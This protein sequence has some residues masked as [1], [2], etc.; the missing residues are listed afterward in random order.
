TIQDVP[1]QLHG[2]GLPAMVEVRGEIYFPT[3]AFADLNA[4][5]VEAGG[6][7]LANPRNAAPGSVGAKEPAVPA[8][9]PLRPVVPGIG[10]REGFAPGKQS[11]A[12]GLLRQWGLPTSD[13][14][15]VVDSLDGVREFVAY[16]A[17]H[18]HDV[19][20]DIDGV[21]VKVD[22][23]AIQGRLGSTSRAPRW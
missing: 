4:S 19:E 16:Y 21:V 1:T 20:H 23:V 12:Y 13:R 7:P 18:R 22:D 14:W 11:D 5:L 10:A 3:E 6:R 15:K 17:D 8:R 9:R 2:D